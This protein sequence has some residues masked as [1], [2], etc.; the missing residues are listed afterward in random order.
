M[1]LKRSFL[2]KFSVFFVMELYETKSDG[3]TAFCSHCQKEIDVTSG[4]ESALNTTN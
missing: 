3:K 1:N 4:G 2:P